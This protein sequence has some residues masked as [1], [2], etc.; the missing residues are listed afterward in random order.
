MTLII[1]LAEEML[2]PRTLFVME[3]AEAIAVHAE[4][5][6][7]ALGLKYNPQRRQAE[8]EDGGRTFRWYWDYPREQTRPWVY[9]YAGI[10][11]SHIAFHTHVDV[12]D[13]NYLI[14][15]VRGR[16]LHEQGS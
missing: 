15:R 12:R 8:A 13:M 16:P 5:F 1:K 2:H 6:C 14:M 11:L 3:D 7:L 4:N 9:A 10:E